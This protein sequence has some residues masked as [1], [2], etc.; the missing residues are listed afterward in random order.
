MK[1]Y[2]ILIALFV[3]IATGPCLAL[4]MDA[5]KKVEMTPVVKCLLT[6]AKG[7]CK[8]MFEKYYYNTKSG[9][10]A[11][12]FWG[13]CDGVVPFESMEECERTC[14]KPV[15]ARIQNLRS[16]NEIYAEVSLEFPKEWDDPMFEIMVDGVEINARHLSGGFSEDRKMVSFLFFPGEPGTKEVAVKVTRGNETISVKETLKWAGQSFIAL[17][18]YGGDRTIVTS[19]EKIR[20]VS[21]NINTQTIRITFNGE[22]VTPDT[23][24]H[25]A[26]LLSFTPKWHA[27]LNTLSVEGK[28]LDRNPVSKNFTFLFTQDGIKVGD[29]GLFRYGTEG[30]KSGPFYTLSVEGN[31]IAVKADRLVDSYTM[32]NDGWIEKE[33][34]LVKEL[35]AVKPGEGRIRILEKPHFLQERQLKEEIPINVVQSGR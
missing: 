10:C 26:Q 8:A 12:F 16:L 34:L 29:T 7:P 33:T 11:P 15:G 18:G 2:I 30:T 24:G 31:S 4:T 5:P 32:S 1:R 20:I 17:L 6:P 22:V 9:N 13:G 27:G 25:H 21:A 23:F 3:L 19:P 14:T 28:G 35:R